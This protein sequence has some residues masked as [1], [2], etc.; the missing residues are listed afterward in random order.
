MTNYISKSTKSK[1][2]QRIINEALDIY[3]NQINNYINLS[4]AQLKLGQPEES[5]STMNTAEM[6]TGNNHP[7]SAV[8]SALLAISYAANNEKDKAANYF[9]KADLLSKG[10]INAMIQVAG[11]LAEF[12]L[13]LDM[14]R[15]KIE[16]ATVK[17]SNDPFNA[18]TL[19]L[20]EFKEKNYT[21]SLKWIESAITNG[22]LNYPSIAEQ[23][24]DVYFMSK[25][26]PKAIELW[27]L[28]K[29][30]GVNSAILDKKLSS[31]SYIQ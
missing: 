28:A 14:A 11:V 2:V 4:F 16:A 9:Q 17:N 3:P 24:G 31:R 18:A 25:N 21:S 29:S 27:N 30:M 20:I 13:R 26:I 10:N 6:M 7:Q 5:I 12:G 23:A 19:S 22:G 8:I 1:S 15:T